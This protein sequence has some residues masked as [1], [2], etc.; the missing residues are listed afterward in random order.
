MGQRFSKR[1][2]SNTK[3]SKNIAPVVVGKSILLNDLNKIDTELTKIKEV[4]KEIN[5]PPTPATV[6]LD[7]DS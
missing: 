5:R 7:N 1:K 2:R 6:L 4:V 3:Q